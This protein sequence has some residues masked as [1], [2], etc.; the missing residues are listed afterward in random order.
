MDTARKALTSTGLRIVL[1]LYAF[2]NLC[3]RTWEKSLGVSVH[4]RKPWLWEIKAGP[5]SG[6][7]RTSL[8]V[9][10]TNP[11]VTVGSCLDGSVVG[12]CLPVLFVCCDGLWGRETSHSICLGSQSSWRTGQT[13]AEFDRVITVTTQT[14][15]MCQLFNWQPRM[16]AMSG[17]PQVTLLWNYRPQTRRKEIFTN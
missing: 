7:W 1:I 6:P 13:K 2:Y 9:I 16:V 10:T 5:P 17:S 3:F 8:C 12:T 14:W 11:T 15:G 4:H